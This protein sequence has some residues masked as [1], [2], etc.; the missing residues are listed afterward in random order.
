MIKLK[1]LNGKEFVLNAEMIR[2]IEEVPDTMITLSTGEKHY[3]S[4]TLD[5]VVKKAVEYGRSLRTFS[6]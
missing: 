2:T 3:V 5:S 1:R 4:D 6:N